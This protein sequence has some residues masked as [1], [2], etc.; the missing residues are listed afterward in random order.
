MFKDRKFTVAFVLLSILI[1][2]LSAVFVYLIIT[3]GKALIRETQPAE[4]EPLPTDKQDEPGP[5][6]LDDGPTG[7]DEN[8]TDFS[9]NPTE[10]Q[11]KN[12]IRSLT[13]EDEHDCPVVGETIPASGTLSILKPGENGAG[14]V[15]HKKPLFD[16]AASEGNK[17]VFSG[18]LKITGKIYILDNGIPYLMYQT[19][20]GY[21][22]TSNSELVK[23]IADNGSAADASCLGSY[24]SHNAGAESVAYSVTVIREDGENIVFSLYETDSS[25][26]YAVLTNVIARYDGYGNAA[27]EYQDDQNAISDGLFRLEDVTY[28]DGKNKKLT[29]VFYSPLMLTAGPLSQLVLEQ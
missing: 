15:L 1:V 9:E 19:E 18:D 14:I 10:D 16:S 12:G 27:F 17:T 13:A 4:T 8:P 21:Y 20:D 3:D 5:S 23:F 22:L 6:I 28:S 25:G 29:I 11:S 24:S 2:F 7:A 26:T